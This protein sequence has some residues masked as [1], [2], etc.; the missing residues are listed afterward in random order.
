MLSRLSCA[1]R[2]ATCTRGTPEQQDSWPTL[3]NALEFLSSWRQPCFAG[4]GSLRVVSSR[5]AFPRHKDCW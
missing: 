5:A 4:L 2:S 3:F 1:T